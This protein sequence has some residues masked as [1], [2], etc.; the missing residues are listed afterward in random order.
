MNKDPI[1][2]NSPLGI[3]KSEWTKVLGA[4]LALLL[5]IYAIALIFTLCGSDFFLLKFHNDEISNIESILR[6]F[7][8]YAI[9]QIA[10]ETIEATIIIAY[11]AKWKI[12]FWVPI[13]VF[14]SFI[15][16][17]LVCWGL[18]GYVP[19]WA[20]FANS[21]LMFVGFAFIFCHS[22]KKEVL[23][24]F[25]RLAIA[26][27]V[28]LLLNGCITL[29]RTQA[30]I[31]WNQDIDSSVDFALNFE[32]DIALV[33]SLILLTLLINFGKK[34]ENEQ[35]LI[36]RVASG[37]SPTSLNSLPKNF[38]KT[39]TQTKTNDISPEAKKR[40][41]KLKVKI[42][43]IQTTALIVIAF[44]PWVVG[45]PV[46]FSL[47]YA[48]FC[49][50]RMTLGFNRSLHFKSELICITAGAF[51]FWLLT[52]LTPSIEVCVI[53]AVVYGS[54]TALGFRLYWELHDLMLYRKAAKLDRY[55]MLY[56][57][58]KG[59]ISRKHIY[60]IMRAKG[61]G[62]EEIDIIILYMEGVKVDAIAIEKNYSK[63][64]IESR[65][66]DIANYLYRNR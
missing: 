41:L 31:M 38:P 32:Y 30:M 65:L 33:L 35:C 15:S 27:A 17:N 20:Q 43:I 6:S 50:T 39:Q 44:L 2:Y 59:N 60:G 18:V 25:I 66:T 34:G 49:L 48:S 57:A 58:F 36:T 56:T 13:V 24:S 62:K 4:N 51:V 63:R 55:A 40:L 52:F 26:L 11:V 14:S 37:S 9:V 61:L 16:V 5:S 53:M 8:V 10:F 21:I 1:D 19:S 42:T 45:R 64:A 3:S 22:S 46:E 12:K 54:A 28:S 23:F 29:F 47:V 7:G